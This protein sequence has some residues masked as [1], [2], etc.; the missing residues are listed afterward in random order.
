MLKTILIL[1]ILSTTYLLP[2]NINNQTPYNELLSQSQIYIDNNKSETIKSIQKRK[3]EN[4]SKKILGYGYSPS[5]AVWI[6]FTLTNRTDQSVEKI[7]EYGNPLTSYVE[8]YEDGELK[9]IDGLLDKSNRRI[10]LNPT[11]KV[12]LE[13]YESKKFYIKAYSK[14]NTLIVKLNLWNSDDF[15]SND[16]N[17][18]II[19]A[20]FFG[21]IGIVFIYSLIIS[22]LTKNLNY[23]L[24]SLFVLTVGFHHFIYKGL[25]KLYF[26]TYTIERLISY[27]SCIVA[28]PILFLALFTQRVLNLK[29]NYPT[30]NRTLNY[31][32]ILY[33]ISMVTIWHTELYQYRSIFVVI[34]LFYLF[35]VTTYIFFKNRNKEVTI[36]FLSWLVFLSSGFFIYLSSVGA[37]DIF[38]RYP[39]YTESVWMVGIVAFFFQ[40]VSSRLKTIEQE[41]KQVKESKLLL[42]EH[43]HRVANLN[44]NILNFVSLQQ[45]QIDNKELQVFLESLKHRIMVTVEIF[46]Q[47]EKKPPS[48]TVNAY[49]YFFLITERLKESFGANHVNIS[50]ESDVLMNSKNTI[51]CCYIVNEAV[52]NA[53][54]YAFIDLDRGKIK[55]SLT[56]TKEEYILKIKDNGRGFKNRKENGTGLE[57]IKK[58][59]TLQL[60]GSLEIAQSS[61]VELTI[62][63]SKDER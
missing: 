3:F 28:L 53:F 2:I 24:F 62:R 43:K 13:P 50:I 23:L 32:L 60:D 40:R 63:W 16:M 58:L 18:K 8:F 25:G 22:L 45:N 6:R 48:K 47:L 52:C 29:E 9:K 19:L 33:P 44:Q 27:S 17:S 49:N 5:Y 55:I 61:G 51:T 42:K 21:A 15:I 34:T 39:H 54:K 56:E 35:T 46:S 57:I 37:Y 4:N 1:L 30:L 10:Y 31:I 26:S 38:E 11:L 12:Y 20:I 14:I 59:A 36:L 7:I 41:K